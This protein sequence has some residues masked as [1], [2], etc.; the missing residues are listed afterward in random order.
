MPTIRNQEFLGRGLLQPLRRLGAG[1]FISSSGIPLVRA[2]ITQIIGTHIGEIR[3]RPRMG[4]R[5]AKYK[6]KPNTDTLSELIS[7]ELEAAIKLHE[8][9]ISTVQV[10]VTREDNVSIAKIIWA[11]I[12]K[13]V[14]GNNV[15]VG[16]DTFSVVI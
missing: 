1:D 15:I 10:T 14:A 16:P 11:I 2:A 13:N 6:H 12:D 4:T 3:W 5:L 7:T 9:R 8:P